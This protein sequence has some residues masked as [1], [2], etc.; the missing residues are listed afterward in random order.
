MTLYSCLEGL[1]ISPFLPSPPP[2]NHKEIC[3][4]FT[5]T[6]FLASVSFVNHGEMIQLMK[7]CHSG[8][9]FCSDLQLCPLLWLTSFICHS[10][11]S[12]CFPQNRTSFF[13]GER[14][15]KDHWLRKCNNFLILVH[16]LFRS[17]N[18]FLI[19]QKKN[20]YES[21]TFEQEIYPLISFHLLFARSGSFHTENVQSRTGYYQEQRNRFLNKKDTIFSLIHLFRSLFSIHKH[22]NDIFIF[23]M[24]CNW[25]LLLCTST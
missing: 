20:L 9:S 21:L 4:P 15:R 17:R 3:C 10:E 1:T 24:I 16:F 11:K 25:R 23:W 22:L 13:L 5:F 14:K 6:P 18:N 2:Q 19:Y 12:G 7:M 8:Q